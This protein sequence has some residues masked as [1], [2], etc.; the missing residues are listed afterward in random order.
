MNAGASPS[1][2]TRKKLKPWRLAQARRSFSY[3][4]IG[5]EEVEVGVV[6]M[7]NELM[8]EQQRNKPPEGGNGS[9]PNGCQEHSNGDVYVN[10]F[11]EWISL[12]H[13]K[14]K[15]PE[16]GNGLRKCLAMNERQMTWINC[17][18]VRCTT[19]CLDYLASNSLADMKDLEVWC[20]TWFHC[21]DS[22]LTPRE[23]ATGGGDHCRQHQLPN[24]SI[25]R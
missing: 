25:N 4:V 16:G 1:P 14:K 15:P 8:N 9:Q 20:S 10:D 3:G 11:H 7:M 5:A 6:V 19:D 12:E 24:T 13:I 17:S 18:I 23:K 2:R 22:E 21:G